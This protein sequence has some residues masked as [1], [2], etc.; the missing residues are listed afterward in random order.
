MHK[1]YQKQKKLEKDPLEKYGK[2]RKLKNN[3][4]GK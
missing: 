2:V 3:G 1:M 4:F